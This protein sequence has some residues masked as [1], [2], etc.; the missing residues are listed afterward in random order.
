MCSGK[1][2][3]HWS[4]HSPIHAS[5]FVRCQS[6]RQRSFTTGTH[7]SFLQRSSHR[8]VIEHTCPLVESPRATSPP[9]RS[10]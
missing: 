6:I 8:M 9:S 7:N 5:R 3:G 2:I 4:T 10:F 1:G